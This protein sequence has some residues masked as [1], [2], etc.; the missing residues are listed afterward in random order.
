MI[1]YMQRKVIGFLIK[2]FLIDLSLTPKSSMTKEQE[3][4]LL[5][6]LWQNDAFRKR[7]AERD[8]K[9]IYTMAGGEG[10]EPEARDRYTLHAGQR[11]ENLLLARDAKAAYQRVEKR[12]TETLA[13]VQEKTS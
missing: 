13:Q 7:I 5:S 12:R 9:I 10:M 2:K 6:M 8:A 11:L 3:D 1:Q 4:G